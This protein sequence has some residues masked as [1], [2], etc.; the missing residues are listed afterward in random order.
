MPEENQ[1]IQGAFGDIYRVETPHLDQALQ[2]IQSNY[3][4]RNTYLQKENQNTEELLNKEMAN[5]RSVDTPQIIDAYNDYKNSKQNQLFNRSIQTNPKA[6]AVAQMDAN[7]KYANLMS[8]INKSSQYNTFGKQLAANRLQKPDNYADDT[9][10]K[11]STFYATPMDKL[12]EASIGGKPTDLTNVDNYRYQGGN[13]DFSK[14]HT[15]AVGKPVTHYD[16]GTTD[17]SGVQS[18]Q[19]GYAYGSTPGQY[20]NTYL[21]GLAG[22][23]ASRAARFSWNQHSNNQQQLDQLDAAYQ[24]SPNWQKMGI[25]PQTLPPYNPNDP[26][27]NE[28]TYQAKQYLVSMNPNE[29]AAKTTVDRGALQNLTSKNRLHGQEVM[30]AIN[31][32]NR[33]KLAGVQHDYK[34]LDTNAQSQVL[35]ET[36]DGMMQKA[37]AGG[38]IKYKSE[39]GTV[40]KQ[41]EIPASP[42]LKKVL[43][44]PDDKGHPIL[45][46]AIRFSPD[47]KT[48]TPLFFKPGQT[49]DMRAVDESVS[50]PMTMGEF[51]ALVGKT[52]FGTREAAKESGTPGTKVTTK[53]S[54]S[55]AVKLQHGAFDNIQ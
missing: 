22:S 52:Y 53:T 25:P 7:S 24:N 19:H 41:Y 34:Q 37:I 10:D 40:T 42:G 55:A 15:T 33:E 30:A 45:P 26:V 23:E 36:V 3:T 5:V 18:T 6:Y 12:T 32:V 20:R 48:V 2:Q 16:D 29:V 46:D 35:D 51:K 14:L 17:E 27:G 44:V 43:S 54:T 31:E 39:N 11:L 49:G 13:F 4:A 9:G 47:T 38:G 1:P 28:A 21:G 50:K 8:M